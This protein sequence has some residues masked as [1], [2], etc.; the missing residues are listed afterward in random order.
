[1][2]LV[3][4]IFL[5]LAVA[6]WLTVGPIAGLVAGAWLLLMLYISGQPG[7]SLFGPGPYSSARRS[8]HEPKADPA[9]QRRA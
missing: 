3:F 2:G 7:A 8:G 1:M 6:A 5:P 4:V 9:K